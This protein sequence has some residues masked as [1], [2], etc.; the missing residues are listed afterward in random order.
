LRTSAI[1]GSILINAG[2]A[3]EALDRLRRT[4]EFEP[5]YWFAHSFAASAY[6]E[7]R[8]FAE[9]ISEARMARE[10]PGV[11]TRPTAFLGYALAKSGRWA[12][13]RRELEG[14]LKLSQQ[15]Y[16][17]SYSIATIYNGLGER[18]ETLQWL[19]RGYRE[20]EP[21]MVFLKAEPMCNNLRG[22]PRFQDLLQ[23]VGL[24]Q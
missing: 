18:V 12:E 6:I 10:F 23:R 3:D 4:L 14:L 22:D 8:M 9:A 2:R 21:R 5:N 24:P 16:V 19:E 17:S 20:R 7:K 11:P 15:R 1:E 13:A